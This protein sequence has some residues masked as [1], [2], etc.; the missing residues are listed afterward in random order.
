MKISVIITNWNGLHLITKSLPQ[1]LSQ[2][3]EANEFI[4]VDDGSA[5]NSL[6]F[7][8]SL[9]KKNKK[10]KILVQEKNLGF[11][12]SSNNGV[13]KSS[14]DL[15]V[16]LNNDIFPEK[17]YIKNSLNHFKNSL[18]F[19][20]G[21]AEVGR[22]N[23][24]RLFWREGYLQY[25]PIFSDKTHITGWLSGGSSIVSRQHFVR[26][27]GF[28]SVYEPFYSEDLDLGYRAW[29]SGYKL[30]WEPK[31]QVV[32]QH[33]STIS[34]INRHFTDYV[35][36]RNRL[37]VVLRNITDPSLKSSNLRGQIFRALLGPNYIKIIRAAR[38][39]LKQHPKPIVFPKLTDKEIF[40]LFTKI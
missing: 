26:L 30:F 1:V 6:D 29:K 12:P 8:N 14:G 20:V 11:I 37:L 2:S 3:P 4:F 16:L 22:E 36:E 38:R 7:V 19:G 40:A 27:G 15:V 9:S 13:N 33:E 18:V 34:R 25:E 24:P 21:F 35:K 10:L 23:W 39:Q 5:D 17:N 32:H 28:D 31:C